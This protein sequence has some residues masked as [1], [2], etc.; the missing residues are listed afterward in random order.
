MNQSPIF[1][2]LTI[3]NMIDMMMKHVLTLVGK[4]YSP[5]LSTRNVPYLLVAGKPGVGRKDVVFIIISLA[6][7]Y[8]GWIIMSAWSYRE[9][10]QLPSER[11][12]HGAAL[13][14]DRVMLI[15]G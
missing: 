5:E 14:N 3:A 12:M 10:C 8:A 4:S 15:Y 1:P 2:F 7:Q 9:V 13:L 6:D 11:Y